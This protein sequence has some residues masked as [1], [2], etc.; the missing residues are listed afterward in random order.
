M[1]PYFI[2]YLQIAFMAS[3]SSFRRVSPYAWITV[4]VLILV[5]VGL[6]HRV[7]MDWNN[8]LWMIERANRGGL[9][10]AFQVAEPGYATLL[11]ISGQ[12]GWGV[13]GAYLMGTF[14]FA[15]GLFRYAWTTPS[16]W[17]ALVVAFPYLIVVV[18]MS[19]ARQAVAIG[20]LLW[21]FARWS[22]SS[23]FYKFFLIVLAANF[24]SSA[25]VF[26]GLVAFDDR[27]RMFSRFILGITSL[28]LLA[29]FVADSDH[30]SFY[31]QAY[32]AG[33]N[34]VAAVEA[35]GALFHVAL[36]AGP[37]AVAF[38]FRRNIRNVLM[39]D[40]LHRHLA[41]AALLMVPIAFIT[42]VGASR[43]SLYLFP[44]SMMIVSSFPLLLKTFSEKKFYCFLVS[45]LYLAVL[46]VWLVFANNA[47]AW[48]NYS[49][50]LFV[51]PSLLILCC[52]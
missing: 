41:Y 10:D 17:L 45:V 40:T 4:F 14:I 50:A 28:A 20:V 34:S 31:Q 38:A 22:Q 48:Q 46:T 33:E 5:F 13:Y 1:A 18:A 12:M 29:Y 3:V 37:A 52:K 43:F 16:P 39:P 11:W 26:L 47:R 2:I 25:I 36:N 24:H 32:F 35:G 19:G 51:D 6:R 44:A 7:G 15:L 42:S 21:L 49:N 9:I 30:F 23:I 8:Y 27:L